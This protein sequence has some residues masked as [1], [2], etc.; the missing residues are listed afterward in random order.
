MSAKQARF[1]AEYLVDGNGTRAAVAAG[2]GQ[3]GA[4]VAASR[5]IRND[6]VQKALQARQ[7][8]DATR[9]SNQREDVLKGLLEAVEAA[10]QQR[11]S[12]AM[13]SGWREIGRMLGFYSPDM[14]HVAVSAGRKADH[15]LCLYEAMSD[16]ELLAIVATA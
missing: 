11:D 13:I 5:L 1:V 15:E 4:P 8:A 14:R 3:A 9:L 10:K 6:K 7:S 2:Y 12:A 16:A